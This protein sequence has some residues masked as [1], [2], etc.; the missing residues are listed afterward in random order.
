LFNH[1]TKGVIVKNV[2]YLLLFA[3]LSTF[4]NYTMQKPWQQQPQR[5]KGRAV[6]LAEDPSGNLKVLLARNAYGTNLWSDF[7]TESNP[8]EKGNAVATRA[9]R[10][11]TN[12]VY[13]IDI[14]HAPHYYKQSP[15]GDWFHFVMV[16]FKAGSELYN[17]ARNAVKDDFFWA[18]ASDIL[19]KSPI[20]HPRRGQIM[21][22]QGV[23]NFL[24]H[25]L[26][27]AINFLTPKSQAA[28]PAVQPI[29]SPTPSAPYKVPVTQPSIPVHPKIVSPTASPV[30]A[31]PPW[32]PHKLNHIYFY[33]SNKPYYEFTNFYHAPINL[34]GKM[35]P[36]S[37]HF[38]QAQK[39]PSNP[40]LQERIR[41]ANTP[42][43]AF[44]ITREPG[45]T[46]EAN[47]DTRKFQ[48]MLEAVRAKFNQHPAL[49]KKLLGTGDAILVEDAGANDKI[50]GAGAD[51]MGGNHLGRIL[52]QVR[53]ELA[54][55]IPAGT[56]YQP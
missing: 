31:G 20:I 11:Q 48:V 30:S 21:I 22:S 26:A 41:N 54:G 8:G 46:P 10:E 39:Y 3:A 7:S 6:L 19:N 38:F 17:R 49:K 28:Q 1:V 9:V 5:W 51:Y 50:W 25:N 15:A 40:G 14:A 53:D 2:R 24:R 36:T 16:P 37:E 13:S 42:R 47:W 34:L 45:N 35:W 23:Y 52:I 29:V 56:V 44:N 32:G 18:S 12:N 4:K 43:A 55:I 27:D 33:D